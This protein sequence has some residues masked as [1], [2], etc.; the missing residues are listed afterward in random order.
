MRW[1]AWQDWHRRRPDEEIKKA[2]TPEFVDAAWQLLTEAE[3]S[4]AAD[5][6]LTRRVKLAQLP[7]MYMKLNRGRGRDAQPY[8]SMLADFEQTARAAGV[9]YVQ[10]SWAAPDF[11]KMLD[12]WRGLGK[13]NFDA[14]S[15]PQLDEGWKFRMDE[16]GVGVDEGWYA[17][18]FHDS[19][20]IR[21]RSETQPGWDGE[22]YFEIG[23]PPGWGWYRR[24]LDV[25]NEMLRQPVV[26]LFYCGSVYQEAEVYVNGKMAFEH[27]TVSTGR[28]A[29]PVYL[30]PFAFDAR[31]F[32]KTGK[33]SITV[34]RL[35]Q[36]LPY[37]RAGGGID[38]KRGVW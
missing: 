14:V 34:R 15:M 13:V 32:L 10:Y 37:I 16:E 4:V 29:W 8:L 12:L 6:E 36:K 24:P 27:T 19:E 22:G 7:I 31:P 11:E 30:E 28:D 38:V 33:N 1:A 20:W 25:S 5:E 17:A 35:V 3:K 23:K 21:V 18:E 26:K 9:Q 2:L